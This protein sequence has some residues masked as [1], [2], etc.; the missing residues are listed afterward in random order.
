MST[1]NGDYTDAQVTIMVAVGILIWAAI[2]LC[3]VSCII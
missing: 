1:E 3:A 2:L